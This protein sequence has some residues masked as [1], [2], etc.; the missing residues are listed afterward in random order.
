MLIEPLQGAW[1]FPAGLG[2]CRPFPPSA[3]GID[4]SWGEGEERCKTAVPSPIRT[5][6]LH[7]SQALPAM[8]VQVVQPDIGGHGATAAVCPPVDIPTVF[9]LTIPLVYCPSKSFQRASSVEKPLPGGEKRSEG[10]ASPHEDW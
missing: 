7:L 9:P 1:G 4:A 6:V 3:H 8:E 10:R 5:T 2:R